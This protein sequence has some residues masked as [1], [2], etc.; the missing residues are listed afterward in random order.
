M[1]LFAKIAFL[2][3]L[4]IFCFDLSQMSSNLLKKAFALV[5]WHFCSG[6]SSFWTRTWPTSLG[7]SGLFFTFPFS[8]FLIFCGSDWPATG[9]SSS[10]QNSE[11]PSSRR[12]FHGPVTCLAGNF[13]LRFSPKFLRI[14]VYILGSTKPISLTWVSLERSFRPAE[15]EYRRCQ[16]W[17]KVM[18]LML[19]TASYSRH[20]VIGIIL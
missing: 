18:T 8:P 5:L 2:D 11:N 16:F 12:F 20:K 10:L 9:L 15:L 3:I 17:S 13:A 14:F 1:E 6:M 19:V 7:F 4:E